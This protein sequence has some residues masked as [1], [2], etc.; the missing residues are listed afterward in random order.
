[1]ASTLIRFNASLR[2]STVLVKETPFTA[3]E[4][5]LRRVR[6]TK[7]DTR[8]EH[9]PGE[10]TDNAVSDVITLPDGEL[11]DWYD[12][13]SYDV[14]PID[15]DGPFFWHFARFGDVI[16]D[17]GEPIDPPSWIPRT[18]L[19]SGCCSSCSSS[20]PCSRAVFLLLPF[21]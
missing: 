10:T 14:T 9:V 18:P 13:Y 5:P 6:T 11:E 3:V 21:V 7:P 2:Y 20:P 1:M 19:A 12:D 17:I 4:V 16:A 8:L 15:D